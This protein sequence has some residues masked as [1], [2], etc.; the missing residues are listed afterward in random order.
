[1]MFEQ[2][3]RNLLIMHSIIINKKIF[4]TIINRSSKEEALPHISQFNF[5]PNTRAAEQYRDLGMNL[6]IPGLPK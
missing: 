2:Q 3:S 6:K 4:N 1:M 5:I